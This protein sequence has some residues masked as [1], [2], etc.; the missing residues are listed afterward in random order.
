MCV[1]GSGLEMAGR[2]GGGAAPERAAAGRGGLG[3]R[4]EREGR[5]WARVG[6]RYHGHGW[7]LL[8]LLTAAAGA[9]AAPSSSGRYKRTD[10]GTGAQAGG[11]GQRRARGVVVR[12]GRVHVGAW[13]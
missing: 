5:A 3:W 7:L 6:T 11:R 8:W 2:G 13:I 1:G 9:G 12:C 4:V 10:R